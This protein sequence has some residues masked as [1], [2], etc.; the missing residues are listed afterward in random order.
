VGRWWARVSSGGEAVTLRAAAP[1]RIVESRRLANAA[2]WGPA[3]PTLVAAHAGAP[4]VARR[5]QAVAG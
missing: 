4:S 5:R 2:R 3:H 1:E